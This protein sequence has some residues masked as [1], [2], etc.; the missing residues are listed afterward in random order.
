MI[1]ECIKTIYGL[2]NDEFEQFLRDINPH[3]TEGVKFETCVS[4]DEYF[5]KENFQAVFI[6]CIRQVNNCLVQIIKKKP[7]HFF[8]GKYYLLTSINSPAINISKCARQILKNDKLN[9]NSYETDLIINENH[10]GE[11][12]LIA[13]TLND[14]N[15]DKFFSKKKMVFIKK[16]NVIPIL[17][18]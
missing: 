3:T 4:T 17:N 9:F 11:L 7:P 18:A 14:Y 6:E 12:G 2:Q 15:P 1:L 13:S 10:E 5:S 8:K 16:D